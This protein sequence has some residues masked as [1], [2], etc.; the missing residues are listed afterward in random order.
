[1]RTS[2]LGALLFS[3]VSLA[4]SPA[5]AQQEVAEKL[6]RLA[7]E[8]DDAD[9]Q[10]IAAIAAARS[11]E[12]LDGLLAT[13]EKMQSL[14]MRREI[15]R[16]LPSFDGGEGGQPA[17]AK[18]ADLAA[19][20][21]QPELREAALEALGRCST[22]GH[23][24]LR[25][26]VDSAVADEVRE[27]AMRLHLTGARAE[28]DD[29]YRELWNPLLERRKDAEGKLLPLE[30]DAIRE[31]AF[32]GL[33]PRLEDAE[34]E[35]TI[36]R[37]PDPKI[38]RAALDRLQAKGSPR[39]REMA[40]WIFERVDYPGSDRANAARVLVAIDGPKAAETFLELAAKRDVTPEDLRREMARLLVELDDANLAKK[41]A[42]QLGKGAPHEKAFALWA[43]AGSA[44]EKVREK[45]RKSLGDKALEV[46]RAAAEVL[47]QWKDT[48]A[49]PELR[50]LLKSKGETRS[51]A[52]DA[53]GAITGPSAAWTEELRTF[54]NDPDANV[55]LSALEQLGAAGEVE[56]LLLA[57]EHEDWSTRLAAAR[58]LEKLRERRAVPILVTRLAVERGRMALAF[59]D[60]LWSLTGQPFGEDAESWARWWTDAGR[61]FQVISR[62]ELAAA[63]EKRE[64]AR[65]QRRTGTPPQFFGVRIRSER[66]I[67]VVDVSGSMT[68][69]VAGRYVGKRGATR[70]DVAKKELR[71]CIEALPSGALF[72]VLAFST[73]IQAWLK[74]GIALRAKQSKED[75][76]Q[77]VDRL[78]AAG[79]TNLYDTLK[80][81]FED[82][83][84]DTLVILSDGEPTNGAVI[85]PFRIRED[86]AYWNRH[87]GIE[88]HAVSIGGNLEVLE[89]IAAD[90]GGTYVRIR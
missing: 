10:L 87:R 85:D 59:G 56:P 11:R 16:A 35:A 42:K 60:I 6:A 21:A 80:M 76:L 65:L 26:I 32:E 78:G 3:F 82:R 15:V 20:A 38:R 51:L 12:A 4:V 58:A 24:Y 74:N 73:G 86:V 41:M 52:L 27:A 77:F 2:P 54:A 66:V 1:M 63:E 47:A 88:I 62:E 5:R 44:D 68:A 64:R 40:R 19:S 18:L 90:A 50:K 13:Y 43:N 37:D 7:S 70:I 46:Q 28:D 53:I 81:A 29:W 79:A 31:L 83:D 39:A 67:F 49:L 14:Y 72:N 23:H 75:A 71:E 8:R 22:Y 33:V 89:G 30:M 55:R 17:T 9:P 61:E 57:L 34:L 48:A 84:V 69:E 45:V 36:Q 25:Q